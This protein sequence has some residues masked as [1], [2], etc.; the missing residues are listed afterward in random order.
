MSFNLSRTQF[1][2][3]FGVMQSIKLINNHTAVGGAPGLLWRNNNIDIDQFAVL[4]D[5]L[6]TTP[7]MPNLGSM[8]S[9][10]TAPILINP[11]TEGGYLPNTGPGFVAIPETGKLNI[12][13]NA[14]FSAM[15]PHIS[16]AFTNLIRRVKSRANSVAMPGA[17]FGNFFI[18]HNPHGPVSE[19]ARICF[20]D[21]DGKVAV[22]EALLPQVFRGDGEDARK[23]ID[24]MR[25]F[26]GQGLIDT[27]IAAGVLTRDKINV[28]SKATEPARQTSEKTLEQK[29]MECPTWATW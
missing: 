21:E 10:S 22:I 26:I 27:D 1:L 11:F 19:R 15:E 13:D 16:T 7:S 18:E 3:M 28:V 25:H 9:G 5:L 23:L 29:L 2:Q 8:P 6:A 24:I 20:G 4:T 17:A 14:L 12:K